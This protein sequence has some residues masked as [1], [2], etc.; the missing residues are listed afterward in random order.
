M[1]KRLINF[2]LYRYHLLPLSTDESQTTM[3]PKKKMKTSEVIEKKNT[4]FKTV[5]NSLVESKNNTN[6]I[7]LHHQDEEYFVFKIAQKKKARITQDFKN[8]TVNNEPYSYVIINND[9]NVQKIAISEN[10]E[11]FSNTDVIKNIIAKVFRKELEP[12][13]LN[14]AIE[15]LFDS[16]NFWEYVEKYKDELT[17]INFQFIK[18]NL[19]AISKSLPAD[20]KKFAEN[21][22]SH[23]S[24]L[25]IK[26][27]EKGVLENINK[28]NSVV[29]GL[30]EYS[31][32]GAGNIKLK[33]KKIRKQLNTSDK[34]V[35]HQID[36][37]EIEGAADQ[38]IKLYK[39][40]V[41]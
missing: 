22:N 7:R 37:L 25:T 35:I 30:V 21:V 16:K 15:P 13:Q 27:P 3:F 18:P 1:E 32:E 26:A 23:E 6:P 8:Q 9:N 40:I 2:R 29:N 24:H 10:S 12:Y 36:E 38:V 14:I 4:F 41:E 34:P 31:S 19:A 17:Y 33:V 28:N 20:F 39:S 5:L 11:A